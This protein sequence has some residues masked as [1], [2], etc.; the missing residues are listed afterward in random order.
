MLHATTK[1]Q[2]SQIIPF[3]SSGYLYVTWVSCSFKTVAPSNAVLPATDLFQLFNQDW[4]SPCSAPDTGLG[5]GDVTREKLQ[6][7]PLES[8]HLVG[9]RGDRGQQWRKAWAEW[10]PSGPQLLLSASWEL[11]ESFE[12][13][14]VLTWQQDPSGYWIQGGLERSGTSPGTPDG[15]PM[16]SSR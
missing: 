12:Q 11:W 13:S 7:L 4:L 5:S 16:Q 6:V 9:C 15:R 3:F 2:F 1:I 14:R 8:W 10:S